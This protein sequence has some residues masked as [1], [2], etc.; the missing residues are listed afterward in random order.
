MSL[1]TLETAYANG[2]VI[3]ASH[4]NELTLAILG[5]FVGRD[6]TG[7]PTPNQS[8]G[9]LAL[10]WGNLYAS[11]V[12]LDGLALDTSLITSLPN[13][14][15]SGKTRALSS[16]PDFLR[17]DG[18]ALA[19]DILGTD[20]DLVLA[21]NNVATSIATDLNKSGI[22]AAPAAN[23]TATINDTDIVND[24][25][26]GESDAAINEIIIDA[27]GSEVSAL[28]GQI[29][30]FKTPTGEIFQGFLETA[31]KIT[32]VFRGFYFDSSGNG[33]SR[34]VLSN[35]DVITLMAIS[36]V[37]VE[38]NGT[39]VDVSNV[40]PSVSFQAPLSPTTGQ[41]WFDISNQVWK[42]YSGTSFD[43]INRILIGQVVADDLAV[44]GARSEDISNSYSNYNNIKVENFSGEI[45]KSSDQ[46]ARVSVYGS[47]VAI[48]K[49]KLTWNI[50]TDLESPAVEA[51]NTDY[52]LYISVEGQEIMS[53]IKPYYRADIKGYYHPYHSHRC[54]GVAFNDS[55]SDLTLE[56]WQR[57]FTASKVSEVEY[58]ELNTLN[59]RGTVNTAIP[60]WSTIVNNSVKWLGEFSVTAA[61][62]ASFKASRR[63]VVQGI[64]GAAGVTMQTGW[65]RNSNQLSTPITS[66]TTNDKVGS[67]NFH[68]GGNDTTPESVSI[69]LQAGDVL[70]PHT[71]IKDM[72]AG[73]GA[74][75][76]MTI[77]GV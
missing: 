58:V 49:T 14:I 64:Y 62:G 42:R 16:M 34:G 35:N 39:T 37:F 5:Q 10:P 13:R 47:E 50:T 68:S 40:T 60:K 66:V 18:A 27:V 57:F 46:S 17:A 77:T 21:I 26:A 24:L 72:T 52:Y 45:I 43:I 56:M 67:S 61:E 4:I 70:R 33:I 48:D 76:S 23:N 53:N 30:A 55:S 25:Y 51:A 54:V 71:S 38:D 69:E 63:C 6:V 31:T 12:I 9:T 36:W 22:V 32:N 3:D 19:F 1:N 44:I 8:L 29:V 11:G 15:V 74:N 65:S 73:A 20:V 28:V 2:D 41:Y 7:V 59:G 75:F